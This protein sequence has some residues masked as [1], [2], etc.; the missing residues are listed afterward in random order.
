[1][2]DRPS[3]MR[4]AFHVALAYLAFGAVW[5][6]GTDQI[7][8]LSA[9]FLT[10]ALV[11]IIASTKGVVFV[12][13]SG[14]L[15][16]FLVRRMLV[17][18]D[19]ESKLTRKFE[20]QFRLIAETITEVFWMTDVGIGRMLYISPG[21]ERVW[22]RS[23]AELYER[24]RSFIE[25]IHPEDRERVIETLRRQEH[26]LTYENEYRIV[27][28]DG[29]LRWIWD[30]G[31][32][33]RDPSGR[34]TCY[35]GVAQ[36]VTGRVHAEER[37]R[38][39]FNHMI[40]GVAYCEAIY[41]GEACVD[42]RY[43]DVNV[44][45]GRLTGLRNAVDRTASTLIPG[46]RDTNPEL[47]EIYGR[48]AR[49]GQP[50]RFETYVPDLVMWFSITA[51]SPEQGRFVAV[52]DII[53]ERKR[54]ESDLRQARA[55]A[56]SASEAKS[57]FLTTMSHELRTPLNAVLGFV[58][59]VKTG[60]FGEV[61]DPRYLEHAD[62]ALVS[63]NHL[64]S[65]IN[66]ILDVAKIEAGKVTLD[67]VALP[68]AAIVESSVR[69]V[70]RSIRAHRHT[71]VLDI[72]AGI[73]DMLGD[74]RA[75]QQILVNLLS[76]A[77]KFTPEGGTLRVSAAEDGDEIAISVIDTGIGIPH[78]WLERVLQPFEQ[79]ETDLA[80]HYDGTGLGLSI[81]KG[82]LSLQSGRLTIKSEVGTGSIITT[83]LPRAKP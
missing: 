67:L 66:D 37:H 69:L 3:S 1:M 59:L 10:P 30:R 51:Y 72:P 56:E 82:L 55:A 38:A 27:W 13:L 25:S 2:I 33:V 31:F 26:G 34:V 57:R 4:Q 53:N 74:E 40:E 80:R 16:N 14:A 24:P 41:E 83:H 64:L 8:Y 46:L 79:M 20:A 9:S 5:V 11:T 47:F 70:N 22:R 71:L 52:F 21:Y 44:A 19:N 77:A 60:T 18:L 65:L 62:D 42:F 45:F 28:P 32:P 15:I 17:R 36:D 76:N 68:V 73:P 78:D 6:I 29:T 49:T 35:V 58:E 12:L 61:G 43:L 54:Y 75:V 48:V 23:C 63:G 81:V 50:E 39:L 7:L